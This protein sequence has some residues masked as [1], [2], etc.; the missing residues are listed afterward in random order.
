V[1]ATRCTH[2]IAIREEGTMVNAYW[3][4]ADT[5]DGAE[6]VLSVNKAILQ[7]EP[8]LWLAVQTLC[9]CMAEHLVRTRL[10]QRVG[11]VELRQPPLHETA[12]HA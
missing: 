12:G 5:L 4:P 11:S 1:T 6:L 3:A 7:A 2:R 8:T 9:Q 10:G